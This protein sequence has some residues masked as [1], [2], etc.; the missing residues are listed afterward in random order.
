[1][2]VVVCR[3]P[4]DISWRRDVQLMLWRPRLFQKKIVPMGLGSE[5]KYSKSRLGN[6]QTRLPTNKDKMEKQLRLL[7]KSRNKVHLWVVIA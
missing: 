6:G 1:M 3:V 2:Q 5:N 7:M 4:Y